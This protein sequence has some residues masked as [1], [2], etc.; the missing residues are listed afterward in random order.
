M[1]RARS[2]DTLEE[3]ARNLTA[4]IPYDQCSVLSAQEVAEYDHEQRAN[5]NDPLRVSSDPSEPRIA[6]FIQDPAED[7]PAAGLSLKLKRRPSEIDL[8]FCKDFIRAFNSDLKVAPSAIKDREVWASLQQSRF[9]RS[10]GRFS[11]LPTEN[12]IRWLR[13]VENAGSL[14]YEGSI[15]SANIFMTKQLKW[16]EQSRKMSFVR[17]SNVMRFED[18]ILRE[19]WVRALL[20]DPLIGLVGL[21]VSSRI[22]GAATFKG[23][24][25]EGV[26]FAPSTSVIPISSAIVPGTMAFIN[27][28][29]GD[30]YLLFPN[31]A[32]FMKAQGR[33]RYLNYSPF[34]ELI[35][36]LLPQDLVAGL[37]RI[38]LDLS[39][40]RRGGLIVIVDDAKMVSK[41]VPDHLK[42]GRANQ[43]LREFANKL[44]I[45]ED[46][47]I[48]LVRGAAAI[49][50]AI[51]VAKDGRI[52]DVAS[53]IGEP[54][55]DDA[56]PQAREVWKDFQVRAL[57]P[58]GMQAYSGW[59]SKYL[60][61]VPL[62]PS[63]KA[64]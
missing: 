40:E 36:Q 61:T 55:H 47:H 24:S 49:D 23:V 58:H 53:M 59:L 19:K 4:V 26:A 17:F 60:R 35:G 31:G 38:V 9:A 48:R 63:G 32:T 22:V 41:L 13:V 25:Q 44:N 2:S 37:T 62:P 16:V 33:W 34:I 51:I 42:V 64:M 50:G 27:S 29:R 3:L 6:V 5:Q 39:Y 30:L 11:P 46:G 1:S 14:R 57:L 12:F 18:A 43:P 21:S 54:N 7:G 52:L 28:P 8:K 56:P 15:F 10:I 20:R 45:L